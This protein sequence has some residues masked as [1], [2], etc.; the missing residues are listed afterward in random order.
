MLQPGE[1]LLWA[2]Q[3]DKRRFLLRGWWAIPFSLLWCGFVFFWERSAFSANAPLFFRLWGFPFIAVGLYL[4]FGRFFAAAR[5]AA[6]TWYAVT[7][8]RILIQGGTFQ[9]TLTEFGLTQ[10]QFVELAGLQGEVGT[11]TF[12]G[13]NPFASFVIPGWPM[14]K[15]QIVP[16]FQAIPN[17]REVY[18]IIKRAQ[19]TR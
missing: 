15:A 10:L 3:T 17:A 18:E 12:G 19:G 16:S 2:G 4:V 1:T 9:Q 8:R 6:N 14:S 7:N 13:Q 5:E 11:I